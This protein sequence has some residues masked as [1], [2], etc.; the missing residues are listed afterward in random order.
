MINDETE[1]GSGTRELLTIFGFI[2]ILI[3][4]GMKDED[5]NKDDD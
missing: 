1:R 4:F 3:Q 2:L 5:E